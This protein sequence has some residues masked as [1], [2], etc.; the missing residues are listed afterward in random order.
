VTDPWARPPEPSE[1]APPSEPPAD[2]AA[3]PDTKEFEPQ[4]YPPPQQYPAAGSADAATP[5][6]RRS[7]AGRLFR[8]PLSIV[9]VVVIVAALTIAGAVGGEL[10]ARHRADS[11]VATATACVVQDGATA[12]FGGGLF[13][14][15]YFSGHYRDISISTAG[16]QVRQAKGMKAQIDIRDVRR[17]DTSSSKGTIGSLDATI[18]WTADGIKQTLQGS[19][20]DLAEQV[21][22]VVD[23]ALARI[24]FVSVILGNKIDAISL[25]KGIS[26]DTVTTDAT[27]GTVAVAFGF[28]SLVK[29]N[30]V[31]KPVVANQ[32]LSLQVVNVNLSG[33]PVPREI[34]QDGLSQVIENLTNN[35][36]LGI[37]ATSVRVTD[38]G[39]V[40]QFGTKDATIPNEQ[41]N[42][43]FAGL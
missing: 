10:Y 34:L 37:K 2:G 12:T 21:K 4:A 26:I 42:G 28:G 15:Q 43:C 5:Q 41:A 6:A 3:G 35:Y 13:L 9:L 38:A 36:P 8:D 17:S 23:Q 31:V 14:P 22:T 20:V 29:G 24:P 30:V 33:Q 19:V 27:G 16:N 25:A 1:P 32:A 40:A 18:T 11:L 7:L 39:V